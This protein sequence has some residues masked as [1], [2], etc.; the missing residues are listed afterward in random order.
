[1]GSRGHLTSVALSFNVA[2][3]ILHKRRGPGVSYGQ[4]ACFKGAQC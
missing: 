4:R 3:I 1:M 2:L